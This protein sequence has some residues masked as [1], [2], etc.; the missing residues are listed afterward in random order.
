MWLY[1]IRKEQSMFPLASQA[2]LC[3]ELTGVLL[4]PNICASH[5]SVSLLLETLNPENQ[6]KHTQAFILKIPTAKT[7]GVLT[8]PRVWNWTLWKCLTNAARKNNTHRRSSEI[9]IHSKCKLC[10]FL[11]VTMLRKIFNLRYFTTALSCSKCTVAAVLL[12]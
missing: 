4:K 12:L 2:F 6:L 8:V 3:R 1:F 9:Q 11:S 5:S 10:D 7:R